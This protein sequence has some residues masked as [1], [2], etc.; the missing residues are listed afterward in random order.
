MSIYNSNA[1]ES[2]SFAPSA[3]A[4]VSEILNHYADLSLDTQLRLISDSMPDIAVILSPERQIVYSNRAL[5]DLLGH[6]GSSEELGLR[7]GELLKC[8]HSSENEWG[9][10]TTESCRYCGAV[11]AIIE[12]QKSKQVTVRECRISSEVNGQQI[13][14]DLQVKASPFVYKDRDYVIFAVKDISD[15]KRRR[16]LERMFFHDVLNTATGLNGLLNA[17]KESSDQAEMLEFIEFA[18]K[19]SN[20]LVEDLMAQRALTSAENGDLALKVVRLNTMQLLHEVAAYLSHHEI[21]SEKRIYVDPFGHSVQIETDQ[22]LLKRVLI[23][24][25]KNALEASRAG[26]MVNLGVKL[27]NTTVRFSVNNPT[28][29]PVEIQKQVFKRSFSTK[30]AD[31]G[32]GTYSVKLL[33]TMYLKGSVD[34]DSDEVNGTTFVL[35]LPLAIEQ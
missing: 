32:I 29:M 11:N 14:Y 25:V 7:P 10:G 8:I 26:D 35:D 22:Q 27:D 34:F 16:A 21:A 12:C 31:R 28:F 3:R 19:A 15:Q 4:G 9:C 18:E 20:D 5:L 2:T 17:M 13:S 6:D 23:N 24:L 33:T 1:R 30:G